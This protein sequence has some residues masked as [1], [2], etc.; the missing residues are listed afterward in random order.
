MRDKAA[1]AASPRPGSVTAQATNQRRFDE[2]TDY[3]AYYAFAADATTVRRQGRAVARNV[4]R[5]LH[6]LREVTLLWTGEAAA[7]A[8]P[9][10]SCAVSGHECRQNAETILGTRPLHAASPDLDRDVWFPPRRRRSTGRALA[11]A[12]RRRERSAASRRPATSPASTSADTTTT[13]RVPREHR[14]PGL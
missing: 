14:P 6:S 1:Q 10:S 7:A 12:S 13:S 11:A 5:A 3:R 8:R 2:E 4:L 9:A